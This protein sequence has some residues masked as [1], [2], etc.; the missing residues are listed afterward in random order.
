M[1]MLAFLRPLARAPAKARNR[2]LA[3]VLAGGTATGVAATA[4]TFTG[5]NEGVRLVAYKDRLAR[6]LPTVC[7]G[8]TRGVALGMR[9]TKAQCDAMLV[10]ALGEFADT[11]VERCVKVPIPDPVYVAFLDLAYNIG[12]GAFCK[13][14]VVRRWNAGDRAGACDALLLFNRAGGRVVPGL[15]ARRQRERALCRMG[16]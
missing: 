9:F 6:D 4:V 10:K 12:A 3:A 2:I 15:T 5:G 8:E 11:S 13:S 16:I 7:Y 14:T 1:A